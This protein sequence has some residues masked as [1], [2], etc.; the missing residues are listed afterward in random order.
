MPASRAAATFLLPIVDE[1]HTPARQRLGQDR[2]EVVLAAQRRL[3]RPEHFA[4]KRTHVRA[5]SQHDRS[6]PCQSSATY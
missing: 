3:L 4:E 5:P 1:Q 2:L 6:L